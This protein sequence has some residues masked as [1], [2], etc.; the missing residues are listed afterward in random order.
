MTWWVI[1]EFSIILPIHHDTVTTRHIFIIKWPGNTTGSKNLTTYPCKFLRFLFWKQCRP[2]LLKVKKNFSIGEI[3][4]Y[5]NLSFFIWRCLL[6]TDVCE[7]IMYKYD[8]ATAKPPSNTKAHINMHINTVCMC[9]H[10]HWFRIFINI[11]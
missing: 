1:M 2:N 4:I 11:S 10:K 3:Q 8:T 9:A 7:C 6:L 5:I